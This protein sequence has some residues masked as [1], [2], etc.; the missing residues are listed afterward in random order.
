MKSIL[1]IINNNHH[2]FFFIKGVIGGRPFF[3]CR[4]GTIVSFAFPLP[5]Y[6]MMAM[7]K[8]CLMDSESG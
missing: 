4:K 7:E 8:P 6:A 5:N 1:R 2:F 3:L